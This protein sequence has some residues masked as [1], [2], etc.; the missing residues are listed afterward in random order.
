MEGRAGYECKDVSVV[1]LAE[2][3]LWRRFV[4]ALVAILWRICRPSLW[5]VITRHESHC[6]PDDVAIERTNQPR[7][8]TIPMRLTVSQCLVPL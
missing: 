5:R 7:R 6:T 4:E 3:I 1:S 8:C 2:A